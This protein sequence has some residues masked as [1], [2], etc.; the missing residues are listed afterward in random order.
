[1]QNITG[2]TIILFPD[3]LQIKLTRIPR[4]LDQQGIASQLGLTYVIENLLAEGTEVNAVNGKL[5]TRDYGTALI[6]APG[7]GDKKIVGML[8]NQYADVNAEGWER[9]SA[10]LQ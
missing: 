5:G 1:M 8:L 7:K 6:F 2:T 4:Q 3:L 10:Q 9:G